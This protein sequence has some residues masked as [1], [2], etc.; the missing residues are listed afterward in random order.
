MDMGTIGLVNRESADYKPSQKT[1]EPQ[2]TQNSQ[3]FFKAANQ[4]PRQGALMRTKNKGLLSSAWQA[5]GW[6]H[7]PYI[8]GIVRASASWPV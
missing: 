4:L 3:I 5:M 6:G 2:I 1:A 7:G 8:A